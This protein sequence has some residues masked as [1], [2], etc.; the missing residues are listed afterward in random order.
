MF[1]GYIVGC[2]HHN[3]KGC[4]VIV[5]TTHDMTDPRWVTLLSARRAATAASFAAERGDWNRAADQTAEHHRLMRAA[6]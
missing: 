6:R 5:M 4:S 2:G 3:H 1:M